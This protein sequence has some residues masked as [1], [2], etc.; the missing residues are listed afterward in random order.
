MITVSAKIDVMKGSLAEIKSASSNVNGINVSPTISS[1]LG[2]KTQPDIKPFMLGKSR[3]GTGS[4]YISELPYLVGRELANSDGEFAN[5]YTITVTSQQV[6]EQM[7]IVFDTIN[8]THPKSIV[9]DGTTYVDDDPQFEIAFSNRN[10]THTITI[11]NWNTP[12]APIIITSIYANANIEIDRQN[13]LSYD[14]SIF[15][16]AN[17]E[18]PSYGIISNGGNISFADYNEQVLDLITQKILHSG[19][20]V[21]IF[22]TNTLT[23]KSEQ[24]AKLNITELTYDNDNRSVDVQLKDSLEEWQEMNVEAINYDPRYPNPQNFKWLYD[25]LWSKTPSK[26]QMLSFDELDEATQNVLTS[27]VI[28]YPLL[29]SDN[30]WNEWDKLCQVCHLNIFVNETGR[31]V[32]K[33]GH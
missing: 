15:D 3:L 26:Y 25:Y 27:T 18:Y 7:I 21:E 5:S 20:T 31:T 28:Q 9:V 10:L 23:Q 16:R 1:A 6:L 8:G 14:S 29:E 12:N 19:I 33:W 17:I 22:L 2:K 30:L 4:Y 24:L 32:C 11:N 13:L